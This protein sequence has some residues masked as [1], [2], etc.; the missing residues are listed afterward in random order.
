[1][2][3]KVWAFDPHSGGETVPVQLRAAIAARLEAYGAKH[4]RVDTRGW[5]CVSVALC[6]ISKHIKNL[7]KN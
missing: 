2:V 6:V 7:Q 4:T 3:N 5:K 1:M